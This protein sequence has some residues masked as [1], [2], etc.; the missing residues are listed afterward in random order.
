MRSAVKRNVLQHKINTQK[1][2]PGLVASY[3][4][5]P[6]NGEVLFLIR[7][8]INL[9][10]TYL[11]GHLPTYLQPRD[12]HGAHATCY[13]CVC[14]TVF[15]SVTSVLWPKAPKIELVF[16]MCVRTVIFEQDHVCLRYLA[17]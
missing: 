14:A 13:V 15:V 6:G 8:F 12:P 7:R 3:D 10:L 16:D 4:I 1:L 2:K 5:R 9:S 11:L 17:W